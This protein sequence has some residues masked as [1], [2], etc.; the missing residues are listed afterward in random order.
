MTGALWIALAAVIA[1]PL[2]SLGVPFIQGW[3]AA[4]NAKLDRLHDQQVTAYREAMAYA[5]DLEGRIAELI[6]E[7]EERSH[8]VA[9]AG[10]PARAMIAAHL[11]LVASRSVFAAWQ[12]L[13][14]AW[15]VLCWNMQQTGPVDEHGS[16]QAP[17]DHVD[18]LAMRHG[19][20]GL[21]R[22]LRDALG[23][24]SR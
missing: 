6:K 5:H 8:R 1:T 18:V 7:P 14:D 16:F 9:F 11:D 21:K 13:V 4:R 23:A 22:A 17:A 3:R 24:A 12:E 15:E 19:I 2:T 20:D 10:L